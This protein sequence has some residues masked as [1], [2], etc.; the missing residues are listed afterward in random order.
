M[1]CKIFVKFLSGHSLFYIRFEKYIALQLMFDNNSTSGY[2]YF[3]Y[4]STSGY[5]YLPKAIKKVRFQSPHNLIN[6]TDS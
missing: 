5:K 2:E 1:K 6:E 3:L 4:D